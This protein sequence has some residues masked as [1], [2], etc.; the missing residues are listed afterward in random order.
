ME[1][2]F[3]QEAALSCT[4]TVYPNVWSSPLISTYV[5]REFKCLVVHLRNQDVQFGHFQAS[6]VQTKSSI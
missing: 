6:G 3:L 2:A 5:L 1:I 4:D